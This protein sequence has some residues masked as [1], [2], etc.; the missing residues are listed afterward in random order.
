[1]EVVAVRPRSI[2]LKMAVLAPM[3]NASVSIATVVNAGLLCSCR[4]A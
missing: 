2:T 4:N 3:P 1:M